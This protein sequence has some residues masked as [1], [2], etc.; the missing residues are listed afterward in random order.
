MTEHISCVR[1]P[2]I[3]Q[4]RHI[5][6]VKK[7]AQVAATLRRTKSGAARLATSIRLSL[8][9]QAKIYIETVKSLFEKARKVVRVR[10]C[11]ECNLAIN[12]S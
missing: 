3:F 5:L 8:V 11:Y 12:K 4:S 7:N 9:A 6:V 2:D 1:I 10:R